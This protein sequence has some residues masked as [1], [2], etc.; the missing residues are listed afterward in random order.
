MQQHVQIGFALVKDIPFLADAAEII[1]AH[2]E[3]YDGGGYPRGIK[4]EEILLGARV[5]ALADT[6]DAI[7]SERPYQR[8]SS[9]ESARETIRRFS[10]SQFDPRVVGVFLSIPQATWPTIA[11]N[12]R[13]AAALSPRFRASTGIHRFGLGI[14]P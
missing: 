3:H 11:R 12:Q 6:L 7:T 9:F 10:S 5:L 14:L 13:Q 1:L 2:H 4:G 8:A